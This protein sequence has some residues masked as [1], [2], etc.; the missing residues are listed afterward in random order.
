MNSKNVVFVSAGML[1]P[2]KRDHILARRQLY[3]NYGALS[4]ATTLDIA[5][6]KVVLHHGEH[7]HPNETL[8]RL[9][10]DSHIPSRYPI[11]I[12][13]PSFYALPWAKVFCQLVKTK[14]PSAKI[15]AGGR[16]VIDPDPNWF[17]TMLPEVD[18]VAPGLAES[19]I[20]RLLTETPLLS[21]SS[22]PTPTFTLNHKLAYEYLKYQPSVEASRGCGMGCQF[23]EERDIPLQNLSHPSHIIKS[24]IKISEQYNGEEIRPYLQSSMFLP[25]AKWSE[26]FAN[27]IRT[28]GIKTKWRT[29]TRVD[30]M[31][32]TTLANLAEAGLSV[33]DLGLETASPRQ[34]LAMSKSKKPD[35]YLRKAE[36]LLNACGKHGIKAKVNILLYAGESNQTLNETRSWLDHNSNYISG[37]SVGPVI[38]YGPPKTSDILVNGW[39]ELGAQPVD[40]KSAAASGITKMHL[41]KEFDENSAEIE[42]LEL[43]RRYMDSDSYFYLKSFS[44]YPRDYSKHTFQNDINNT[45]AKNLPFRL[46]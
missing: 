3:L 9:I 29:E 42:S 21:R 18:I 28:A 45:N 12:S 2:K 4:L 25:T 31:Q 6:Y 15:I 44:Y 27:E 19:Y 38:A 26:V 43:S 16:W 22:V 30:A 13:I 39:K 34:I 1:Y 37:I 36:Q 24:L 46:N 33:I 7:N 8:E 20:E 11:M 41:S 35:H 14:F 40:P 32:L 10:A 17:K 23:C 5:G